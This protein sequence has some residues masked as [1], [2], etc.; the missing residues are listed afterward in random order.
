MRPTAMTRP[1]GST[2]ATRNTRRFEEGIGRRDLAVID[3]LFSPKEAELARKASKHWHAVGPDLRY[4][5]EDV[6]VEGNKGVVSWTCVETHTGELWGI[7]PTGKKVKSAGI[8]IMRIEN[9]KVVES[10]GQW[11]ALD[12]LIQLGAIPRMIIPNS[13]AW[14]A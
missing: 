5:I 2:V 10:R 1:Q 3:E 14:K 7:A 8:L 4:T 11:S 12:F 13:K 9:G 6:I